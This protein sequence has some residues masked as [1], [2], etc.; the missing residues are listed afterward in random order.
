[1]KIRTHLRGDIRR[2]SAFPKGSLL[3]FNILLDAG[4]RSTTAASNKMRCT[5]EHVLPVMLEGGR[6]AAE[7]ERAAAA[8]PPFD[9]FSVTSR[10]IPE[11]R[12]VLLPC[13][14]G[15]VGRKRQKLRLNS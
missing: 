7:Q 4:K 3:L 1:M 11:S 9:P 2:G 6:V 8:R 13:L 14:L 5:P 12:E 10:D 15:C